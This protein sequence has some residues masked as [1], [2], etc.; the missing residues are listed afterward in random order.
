MIVEVVQIELVFQKDSRFMGLDLGTLL[1]WR[2]DHFFN[3]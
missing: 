3:D 2:I 1:A